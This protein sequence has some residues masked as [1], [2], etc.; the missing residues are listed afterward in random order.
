MSCG[1]DSGSGQLKSTVTGMILAPERRAAASSRC[2]RLEGA[3]G[4]ELVS[5]E[6]YLSRY[7]QYS[8]AAAGSGHSMQEVIIKIVCV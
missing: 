4:A 2:R 1:S 7:T 3:A 6:S 5:M 8:T